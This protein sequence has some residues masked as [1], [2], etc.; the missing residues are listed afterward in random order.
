MIYEHIKDGM[1]GTYLRRTE[2]PITNRP[3]AGWSPAVPATNN[4]PLPALTGNRANQPAD[5]AA[6]RPSF[7]II[8]PLPAERQGRK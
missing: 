6:N 7:A 8:G 1:T 4:A 3:V 2:E 5:R